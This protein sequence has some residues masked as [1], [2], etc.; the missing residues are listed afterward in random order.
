MTR[1]LINL[2]VGMATIAGTM[3][4]MGWNAWTTCVQTAGQICV[5]DAGLYNL[6]RQLDVANGVRISGN[7]VTP[8]STLIRRTTAYNGTLLY[9]GVN[10]T[11]TIENIAFDGY[12]DTNNLCPSYNL[13]SYEVHVAG[14]ATIDRVAFSNSRGASLVMVHGILTNSLVEGSRSTGMFLYGGTVSGTDFWE[15]GT[16]ALNLTGTSA[17]TVHASYFYLNRWEMP[18]WSGGGQIYIDFDSSN[19]TVY[20]NTIDGAGYVAGDSPH[21]ACAVPIGQ[22][23]SGIEVEPRSSSNSVYA[24][25]II[26]HTE[27]GIIANQVSGLT[28]SGYDR[29]LCPTSNCGGR[30]I[31]DNGKSGYV[32]NGIHIIN[33]GG[34]LNP[35]SNVSSGIVL[36]SILSRYNTGIAVNVA[37]PT[38]GP[39]WKGNH[40]LHPSFTT[41]LNFTW[42]Y[43]ASTTTCP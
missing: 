14:F 43:P 19:A 8:K 16:A 13:S 3:S 32:A 36:D 12:R 4:G 1:L 24:N 20:N 40:C 31:H 38:L 42:V 7:G 25:E 27:S 5:L 17:K 10:N 6:D 11:V 15:N 28:L 22:R 35:P 2:L 37:A 9:I 33:D 23:V 39:G 30:Y 29:V 21:P 34:N 18:D 41:S 26:G